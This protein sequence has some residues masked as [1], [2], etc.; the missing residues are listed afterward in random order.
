[1]V[2]CALAGGEAG[3]SDR[4]SVGHPQPAE[5]ALDYSFDSSI[6]SESRDAVEVSGSALEAGSVTGWRPVVH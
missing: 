6:G 3:Q 2:P 1:V 4:H 5:E